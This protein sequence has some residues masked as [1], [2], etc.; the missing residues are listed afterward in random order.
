MYVIGLR[1]REKL[2]HQSIPVCRRDGI[3]QEPAIEAQRVF[4]CGDVV[5]HGISDR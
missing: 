1:S 5:F 3:E 4:E 2:A